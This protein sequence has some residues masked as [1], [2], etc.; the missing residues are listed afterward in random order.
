MLQ[1]I[2]SKKVDLPVIYL[3]EN[4]QDF[5]MLPKGL[6]YIVGSQKDLS[7]I[8]V[9]LE[10]QVLYKSC[11]KT[12]LP[13]KWLDTLKRLGYKTNGMKEYELTSGGSYWENKGDNY[14][15]TIDDFVEDQY[16]VNFDKLAELKILPKWLDDLRASIETN[17]ID[18]VMFDPMAFNKQ[19]GFNAGSAN[20]KHNMKNLLILD[21][22]SSM[23]KAVVLTITNLAKLMSKK[24]YAD[25]ILTGKESYLVDYE[26]VPNH[27]I[28]GAVKS[29]GGG[30]EGKM[31]V[32]IVKQTKNYN[33]VISFGDNDSPDYYF[34]K[35][36]KCNFTCETLL[37]LHTEGHRTNNLTGFSKCFTPKTTEIIK[38]WLSTI[39]VN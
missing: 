13:L 25:V 1:K 16:L 18:E 30:N 14:V 31:F 28:V 33:T 3:V 23:P 29:Y 15:V 19:L 37:S 35:N 38:D 20:V 4:E 39:K 24:F 7:F 2:I 6:P 8:T 21:I 27:D 26:D 36:S 12:G 34:D 11:L 9:F 5:K 32:D 22:S 17:I 10:F